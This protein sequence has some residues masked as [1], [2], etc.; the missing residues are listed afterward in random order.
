MASVR[1]I[2]EA[3]DQSKG[4]ILYAENWVYAPAIQ[5]EREILEKTNGQILWM[6]GEESHSG[7]HSEAYGHWKFNGGGSL[8]GKGV[9]PL[10]AALYLKRVEGRARLGK[11]IRPKTVTARTHSITSLE[12]FEDKGFLSYSIPSIILIRVTEAAAFFPNRVSG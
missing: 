10:S 3:E 6:N 5:K 12:K 2:L 8:V 11:P 4:R 1:R 7:S 9:H